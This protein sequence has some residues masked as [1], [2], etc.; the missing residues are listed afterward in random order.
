DPDIAG[1]TSWAVSTAPYRY[2]ARFTLHA[3]AAVVAERVPPT[4]GV[5]EAL[6]DTSCELRTGADSLDALAMHV[7]LIGVEFEVHEPAELRDRVREL[8]GRLGRAAP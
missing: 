5:V 2:R 6:D 7:A 3:S 8:A 1:Y 4:T